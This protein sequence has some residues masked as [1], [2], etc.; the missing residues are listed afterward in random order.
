MLRRRGPS[1][2]PDCLLGAELSQADLIRTDRRLGEFVDTAKI[3][4]EL[5]DHGDGPACRWNGHGRSDHGCDTTPQSAG[6]VGGKCCNTDENDGRS[7]G[8]Q[9]TG[10]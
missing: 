10:R 4:E 3:A 1:R 6:A 7:G 2:S 5:V 8:R 9:A